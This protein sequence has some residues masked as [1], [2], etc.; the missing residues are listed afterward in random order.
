[1]EK[2]NIVIVVMTGVYSFLFYNEYLGINMLIFSTL[3]IVGFLLLKNELVKNSSW[4]V[5]ALSTLISGVFGSIYGNSLSFFVNFFSLLI[6]SGIS[7]SSRTSIFFSI[8][9]GIISLISS[10]YYFILNLLKKRNNESENNKWKKKLF[11]IIVPL[12]IT[13]VFFLMYKN[14]N[15]IFSSFADKINL[16]WIS[17]YWVFFTLTGL[18]IIYGFYNP[19]VLKELKSVDEVESLKIQNIENP[20]LLL[21]GKEIAVIDEFF[22]GK[23]LFGLLNVLIFLVNLLD[24]NFIFFNNKLPEGVTFAQF[25]HQGVGM[26]IVSIIISIIIVL[27]YFRGS[28]NFIEKS[29][30][31]K[32]LAY[33]WILQNIFMLISVCLK[34]HL[35]IDSY[36]LTYKRIGIYVYALLTIIG[37]VTTY[38]KVRNTQKNLFL[39][40][41]NGWTFYSVFVLSSFINWDQLIVD[42][43]QKGKHE[44]DIYYMLSMS[45][46]TLPSLIS[47]SKKIT[48]S[49]KREIYNRRLSD[50]IDNFKEV[51]VQKTWKSWVFNYSKVKSQLLIK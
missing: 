8:T 30:V 36:G 3:L 1:M 22:S 44:I 12:I 47:Y 10:P 29:K 5:V 15:P 33:L 18:I 35:Y 26:L 27:F 9:Y 24:F 17:G 2:K 50:K 46:S 13:M 31:L 6:L 14:S 34:N 25:L 4:L 43:N 49:K 45:D 28:L 41:V 11:L 23:V 51:E 40:R 7:I 16:D 39:I 21:F 38:L 37:L 19:F 20:K 32:Y 42:Y 48:D